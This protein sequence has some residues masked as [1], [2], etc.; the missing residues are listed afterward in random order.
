MLFNYCNQVIPIDK[1]KENIGQ[2]WATINVISELSSMCL[3]V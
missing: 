1:S 2:P 3:G